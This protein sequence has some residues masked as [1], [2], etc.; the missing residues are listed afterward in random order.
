VVGVVACFLL[1][2]YVFYVVLLKFHFLGDCFAGTAFGYICA[3]IVISLYKILH[4][5][6]N[7]EII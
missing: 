3:A 5:K 1:G 4:W 7:S 6:D 2:F